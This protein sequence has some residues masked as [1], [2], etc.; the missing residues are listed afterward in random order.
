MTSALQNR[1]VGT[2]IVVALVVIFVPEFLDGEK[3]TNNQTFVDVPPVSQLV[4]VQPVEP[5]N[6]SQITEQ[7]QREENITDDVAIDANL[8]DASRE[9]TIPQKN[10]QSSSDESLTQENPTTSTSDENTGNGENLPNDNNEPSLETLENTDDIAESK[11]DNNSVDTERQNSSSSNLDKISI[12]DTGWVVQL[13]SFQHEKNVKSLLKT[14]NDAG[15]R[16]YT[17]PVTNSVGI[18]LTKVFVGP[19][20]DKQKLELALPHL[21]EI[22]K[23]KGKITPFEVSAN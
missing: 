16:V 7:L 13:G 15:Y 5:V 18:R 4:Q 2:I 9:D 21:L 17:R 11:S 10:K 22:T 3:R 23:L 1:L 8:Q 20:L 14:L 6:T 12:Q 19:E